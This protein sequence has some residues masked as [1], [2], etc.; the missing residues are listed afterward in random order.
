MFAWINSPPITAVYS[1]TQKKHNVQSWFCNSV[2]NQGIWDHQDCPGLWFQ[3]SCPTGCPEVAQRGK[4][5]L[6]LQ[7]SLHWPS[8]VENIFVFISRPLLAQ[9]ENSQTRPK[10]KKKKSVNLI[11][12]CEEAKCYPKEK[13]AICSFH[14]IYWLVSSNV[15]HP[16]F[17]STRG[18]WCNVDETPAGF[19]FSWGL[20]QL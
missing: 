5:L 10:K 11:F 9:Q 12:H 3:T 15:L 20:H 7:L 6:P 8:E 17:L 16:F 14:F 18:R 13:Q 19:I 4:L 2:V 1:L